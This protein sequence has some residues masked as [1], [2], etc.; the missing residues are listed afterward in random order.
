MAYEKRYISEN[1]DFEIWQIYDDGRS[2][3]VT[4]YEF[5]ADYDPT[6]VIEVP[7]IEIE[8]QNP[9]PVEVEIPFEEKRQ[10]KYSELKTQYLNVLKLG[11]PVTFNNSSN[12]VIST[13]FDCQE[14]H[15]NDWIKGLTFITTALELGLFQENGTTTIRDYYNNN[16]EVTI[17]E[18]KLLILQIGQYCYTL[19]ET[20]WGYVTMIDNAK[21]TYELSIISWGFDQ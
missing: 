13:R 8:N 17:Q 9:D 2:R 14:T 10:L 5:R 6:T 21:N 11:C 7:Y 18:Y 12:D 20:Y 3:R 16:H 19:R 4:N 1:G 15:Q